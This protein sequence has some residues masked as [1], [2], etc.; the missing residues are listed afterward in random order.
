[1]IIVS[2]DF[3]NKFENEYIEKVIIPTSENIIKVNTKQFFDLD[4]NIV[5]NSKL[6]VVYSPSYEK[7]YQEIDNF[8]KKINITYSLIHLSDEGLEGE[9]EHYKNAEFVLRSYF[10]PRIKKKSVLQFLLD[11]KVAI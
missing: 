11:F 2:S 3:Q 10:D 1:M 5:N 6:I 8:L 7:I 9:N 4:E